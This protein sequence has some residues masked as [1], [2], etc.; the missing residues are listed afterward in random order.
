MIW[1][2]LPGF[3]IK[4]VFFFSLG[5]YLAYGFGRKTIQWYINSPCVNSIICLI[6]TIMMVFSYQNWQ[7]RSIIYPW[8]ILSALVVLYKVAHSFTRKGYAFPSLMTESCFFIFAFHMFVLISKGLFMDL[9][10]IPKP[11]TP[12]SLI[13]WYFLNPAIA[14]ACSVFCFY[15]LKR[16]T[17]R[18]CYML[19]GQK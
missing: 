7:L 16:Y 12:L 17:P 4:S 1:L 2:V 9:F 18:L 5:G 15:L 6:L 13:L 19:T 11:E 14:V 3:S 8:F 10:D